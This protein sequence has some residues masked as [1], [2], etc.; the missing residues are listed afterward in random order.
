MHQALV[1]VESARKFEPDIHINIAY[2]EASLP[3]EEQKKLFGEN[4]YWHLKGKPVSFT[5]LYKERPNFMLELFNEGYDKVLHIGSDILFLQDFSLYFIN[6]TWACPHI[7]KLPLNAYQARNIHRTGLL[8][9]DLVMWDNNS[10]TRKFLNWQYEM[11]KQVNSNKEGFFF[12][13]TYLDYGLMLGYI[14]L[15]E[16]PG[17]NVAYYNLHEREVQYATTFQFSGFVERIPSMLTKYKVDDKL[18]TYEVVTLAI[19]Y[20]EAL[21]EAKKK[22]FNT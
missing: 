7:L 20:G 13:Q 3:T 2:F 17:D 8:N 19:N 22:L 6:H 21:N 14:K 5:E 11:L 10:S 1:A 18:L 16:Y 15:Q 4:T 12:D 9:S